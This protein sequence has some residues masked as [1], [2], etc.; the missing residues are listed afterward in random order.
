MAMRTLLVAG[1][2]ILLGASTARAGDT[3]TF[4]K[5]VLP[6]LQTHCQSCHRPGEVAPMSLVT[7]EQAR[8]WAAGIKKATQLKQMP[9]WFA[10]PGYGHYANEAEKVLSP[11]E[12]ET[13]AAWA[14]NGAP[15][16]DPAAAP[17]ARVFP[18]GWN[19]TPDIVIEMPKAFE[20]PARGT[21]NYKYVL[22]KTNFPE[23]MWVVSAEMRPGNPAVLHHGKV[24]VRPPGSKWM[25]NAVPG[26]AYEME[27][28]RDI[29]GRNAVEDGND[30][31]GKFNPGLGPQRFDRQGAAKFIPKGSDLIYELHY[32]TSGTPTSDVSKLGLVLSKTPPD[33]RYY[34][35]A[36]PTALNLAIPPGE[37]AAEVVS[38][39]TLGENAQLVYA[40]PH[41]HL[42]GKD[43]EL[44][45]VSPAG[46]SRIVLKGRFN[47]EWQMGYE[48]AEPVAIPKGSK[49]QFITHF[50]NSPANRFN[51]D[52]MTKV[53]WGPQNWDE[54]S[55][56]FIGVVFD[57][58]T[59]PE[60]V[61]LKSGPSLLP[62]SESGPTLE[63]L[64]RPDAKHAAPAGN[65][66]PG[67]FDEK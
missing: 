19:I 14:D 40:Q 66:G 5:D 29:L 50:D 15:A 51:P 6:I 48:L 24:W 57:R 65:G 8:P 61:F 46:D 67:D 25:E 22:V 35:H 18:T 53:V 47:F 56:C 58:S 20:L 60:K 36:G 28:Q 34:F 38:E 52:P 37:G 9:P 32:T 23:D 17:A 55:N 1:A 59:S 45:V 21:I 49:I 31:L 64:N 4:Y 7:Y 43:F 30:I 3:P 33:T 2:S 44:R 11:P 62:R 16:G 42:R 27:T 39:V 54:M 41:M 63:A 13:L 10:E 12:L 26:E